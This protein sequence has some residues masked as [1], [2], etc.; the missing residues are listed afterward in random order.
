MWFVF[1]RQPYLFET[2][3]QAVFLFPRFLVDLL[4]AS[5]ITL[6]LSTIKCIKTHQYNIEKF[7]NPAQNVVLRYI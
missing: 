1:G 2:A 5:K 6:V 3:R 4:S 7:H